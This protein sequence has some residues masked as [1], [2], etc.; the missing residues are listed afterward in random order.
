MIKDYLN[1]LDMGSTNVEQKA[2]EVAEKSTLFMMHSENVTHGWLSNDTLPFMKQKQARENYFTSNGKKLFF[3]LKNTET[4]TLR[5]RVYFQ[6]GN[7]QY[8]NN[9]HRWSLLQG[10]L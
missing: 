4:D 3:I 6:K 10:N 1:F 5:Y 8:E 7:N 2:P 9:N